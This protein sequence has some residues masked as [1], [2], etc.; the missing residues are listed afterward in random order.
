MKPAVEISNAGAKGIFLRSA[1]KK[2]RR[3]KVSS[4]SGARTHVVASDKRKR[5]IE[6]SSRSFRRDALSAGSGSSASLTIV[7]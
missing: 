2:N 4:M 7:E 3:K 1:T 5:G 6:V